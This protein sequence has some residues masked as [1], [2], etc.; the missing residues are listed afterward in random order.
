VLAEIYVIKYMLI[1]PDLYLTLI[2]KRHSTY[3]TGGVECE[4]KNSF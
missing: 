4:D 2:L 1:L 3:Q